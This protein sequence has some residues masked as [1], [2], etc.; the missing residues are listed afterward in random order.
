[1]EHAIPNNSVPAR[2]LERGDGPIAGVAAGL[3]NY[4]QVDPTMVRLGLV[5]ASVVAFPTIPITYLA[6]W[7]IIPR[8]DE[9]GVLATPAPAPAPAPTSTPPPAPAPQPPEADEPGVEATEP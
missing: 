8:A 6:A 1:M 9:P 2:R 5:A 4:F 7:M 3:A